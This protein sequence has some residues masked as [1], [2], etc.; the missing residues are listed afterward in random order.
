MESVFRC[1]LKQFLDHYVVGLD[2]K[3]DYSVSAVNVDDLHLRDELVQHF[4]ENNDTP[5]ELQDVT[6]GSLSLQATDVGK[7]Q[8]VAS[9]VVL[10]FDLV[11]VKALGKAWIAG[12]EA[13]AAASP[14][15]IRPVE[16][17]P[18]NGNGGYWSALFNDKPPPPPVEITANY[19]LTHLNPRTRRRGNV[20]ITECN[21]CKTKVQ[22]NFKTLAVCICC[23]L[24]HA[25][26]L[27]CGRGD[28]PFR[29]P[30]S[31]ALPI[32][33]AERRRR[34]HSTAGAAQSAAAPAHV[35][36]RRP[37]PAT[38]PLDMKPC[39]DRTGGEVPEDDEMDDGFPAVHPSND[40][41]A[42]EFH[43]HPRPQPR[44]QPRPVQG[45]DCPLQPP[46]SQSGPLLG[47]GYVPPSP[48]DF[49]ISNFE[50]L[51][52]DSPSD[53]KLHPLRLQRG[54]ARSSSNLGWEV[55]PDESAYMHES[56]RAS[57]PIA[58]TESAQWETSAFEMVLP[59]PVPS[60]GLDA[61]AALSPKQSRSPGRV[62][63][64]LSR[65]PSGRPRR[66]STAETSAKIA[67]GC[68]VQTSC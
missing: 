9:N 53:R 28:M 12:Q 11:P 54:I 39:G 8:V 61:Q 15:F 33:E 36:S 24:K 17:L 51:G 31:A 27:H 21:V 63:K 67:K 50:G 62:S 42:S 68:K 16:D 37:P 44:P 45:H 35:P 7:L 38:V 48:R 56:A 25:R 65:S 29:V 6:I 2:G 49:R 66:A 10:D 30:A 26:C 34:L 58:A 22:T 19:C 55:E 59:L 64:K 60:S 32:L 41:G 20:R 18:S 47:A 3:I 46:Q 52:N 5:F 4:R 13:Q 14:G 23:S 40:S 57:W 43:P 1:I